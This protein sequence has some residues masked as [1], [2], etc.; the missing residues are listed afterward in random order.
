MEAPERLPPV[1][2]RAEVPAFTREDDEREFWGSHSFGDRLLEQMRPVPYEDG[3]AMTTEDKPCPE[4]PNCLGCLYDKQLPEDEHRAALDALNRSAEYERAD[5]YRILVERGE[6]WP[7]DAARALGTDMGWSQERTESMMQRWMDNN[8]E[9]MKRK[10]Q[11]E[12]D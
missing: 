11:T 9:S 12:K 3:E 8:P 1:N 4:G 10:R 7:D 6:M 2:D 5:H